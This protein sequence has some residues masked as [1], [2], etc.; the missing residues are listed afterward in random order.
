MRLRE[1]VLRLWG[2]WRG[3][4][5]DQ[6]LEQELKLHLELAE[7]EARRR[8][9]SGPEAAREARVRFGKS[10]NAMEALVGHNI[11][12]LVAK[13]PIDVDAAKRFDLPV[14]VQNGFAIVAHAV[15]PGT[16]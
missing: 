2:T 11:S 12:A 13:A 15:P 10:T 16:M 14:F 1:W 9:Q 7:E 8:G 6:D 4:R 3:T 5:T